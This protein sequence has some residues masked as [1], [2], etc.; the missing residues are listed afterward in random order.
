MFIAKNG[1]KVK[2]HYTGKLE[3]GNIFDSS[4]GRDPLEFVIGE[5]QVLKKFEETVEGLS[6]GESANVHIPSAEAYGVRHEELVAKVPKANLPANL[7][8]EIG[9]K[10]Q[11]QSPDGSVMV[12]KITE[13][14]ESEVTIDANH[15]LADKNLNFEIEL[16]EIVK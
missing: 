4:A 14:G 5:N 6:V 9:M 10:L 2:V 1:D 16:V 7:T 11:T 3:D 13:I 12:V 8:P 15:E